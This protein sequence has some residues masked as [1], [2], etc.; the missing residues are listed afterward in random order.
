MLHGT[1]PPA[2]TD[3]RS[4][5]ER[6]NS[7]AL[8]IICWIAT[9][10][11]RLPA[12]LLLYPITLYFFISAGQAR[13]MSRRFLQRVGTRRVHGGH[14]LRHLHTFAAVILD[15]VYFLRGE[16][17]RFDIRLHLAPGTRE[18]LAEERGA[19]MI[20]AH[21][22]SFDALRALGLQNRRA[23]L[24]V[25]MHHDHNQLITQFLETLNPGFAE[26]VIPLGRPDTLLRTKEWVEEGGCVALLGDRVF[27]T[28]DDARGRSLTCDFLGHP[29]QLPTGPIRLAGTLRIPVMLFF[30]IYRGGNRYDV[31]LEWLTDAEE[32][33]AHRDPQVLQRLV[34]RYAARLE[35]YSLDAPCNW[36][37][38]HDF[39]R[40]AESNDRPAQAGPAHRVHE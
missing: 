19:L 32:V 25:L 20:G 23:K 6:G 22:G 4:Q 11:G 29:A 40:S 13:R 15:R 8:H 12:R 39:W 14:V 37:N 27:E 17:E 21:V 26:T 31:Y 28:G 16:L 2:A 9:R 3:W 5:P 18:H 7:L 36:F 35:A 33:A 34:Q 38:F 30:A 24:R 10:I 1:D